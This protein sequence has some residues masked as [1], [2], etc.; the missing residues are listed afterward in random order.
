MVKLPD[1]SPLPT[2]A[3]L[4]ALREA[5]RRRNSERAKRAWAKRRQ[6]VECDWPG[7]SQIFRRSRGRS[8][9]LAASFPGVPGLDSLCLTH[10]LALIKRLREKREKEVVS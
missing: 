2:L 5:K 8:K 4:P 9:F 3:E 1:L 6:K 10:I 7:C